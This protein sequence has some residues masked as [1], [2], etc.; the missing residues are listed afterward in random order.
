[1]QKDVFNFMEELPA[2]LR[3]ELAMAIH[4]KM[5]SGIKF[6]QRQRQKFYCLDQHVFATLSTFKRMNSFIKKEKQLQKVSLI[7]SSLIILVYF[8]VS[9]SAGFVI[10]RFNN[11][12]YI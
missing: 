1:M 8:M 3:L 6:F 4:K 11:K 10:P 12:V 5:Y 2:K 7:L 9:G